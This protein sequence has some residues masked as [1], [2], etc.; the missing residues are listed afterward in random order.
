MSGILLRIYYNKFGVR[1]R[2]RLVDIRL[3]LPQLKEDGLFD[4]PAQFLILHL[5]ELAAVD[6]VDLANSASLGE[7]LLIVS[8]D[9]LL[10]GGATAA[11]RSGP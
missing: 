11:L 2:G 9:L 10:D 4:G 3:K 7:L 6:Q 8:V 1:F 5:Q